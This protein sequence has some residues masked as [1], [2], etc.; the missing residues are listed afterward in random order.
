[1]YTDFGQIVYRIT[2]QTVHSA[3]VCVRIGTASMVDSGDATT[4]AADSACCFL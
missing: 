4:T 3:V 2:G 1:M